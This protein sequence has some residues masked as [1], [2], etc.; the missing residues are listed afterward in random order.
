MPTIEKT[1]RVYVIVT[2]DRYLGQQALADLLGRLTGGDPSGVAQF[3]G[4]TAS[5]AEVLDEART[6]SLLG[7]N[8][9]VVVDDADDFISEHRAALERYCSA[10]AE[11]SSLVFVCQSLPSNTR[12]HKIIAKIGQVIAIRPVTGR[13]LVDWIARQ[14]RVAHGKVV[15]QTTAERL[16]D[17]V[18]DSSGLLDAEL[19][20]LATYVG[21]RPEIAEA[22]VEA[23]SGS[24]REEKVFAVMDAVFAGNAAEAMK[25]WEQVLATD[26]AAPG[27]AIAG[28]AWSVRRLLA[29]KLDHEA[30][31]SAYELAQKLFTDP[32]TAE[33]LLRSVDRERLL[34]MQRDLLAADVAVKTSGSSME[35]SIEKFIVKHSVGGR[36]LG[37]TVG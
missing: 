12:L 25:Q 2:A 31:V 1:K 28:L 22:D 26:R 5:L 30:G 24:T 29:V 33:R 37:V 7:G 11:V 18:G 8:R 32:R 3:R 9:T 34:D 36:S 21:D 19:S 35:S 15:S 10:P 20:K 27:R 4:G 16:R 14:A 6:P 23:L 13:N 17:Q